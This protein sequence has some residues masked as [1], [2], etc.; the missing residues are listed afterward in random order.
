ML[1][2]TQDYIATDELQSIEEDVF[3]NG[4]LLLTYFLYASILR[5]KS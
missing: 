2:I 3:F 4:I 1:G 5:F